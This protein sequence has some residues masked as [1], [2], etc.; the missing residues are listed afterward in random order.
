MVTKMIRHH[1]QD[2]REQD[3]SYHWDTVRLVLL[4][5]FAQ[6]GAGTFSNNQWIHMIHEGSS[7][8]IVEH[9]L[10][11]KKSLCSLR[12]I[13]GD[14][15]GIP[16]RPEMIGYNDWEEFTLRR[17]SS[18]DAQSIKGSGLIPGGKGNDSSRQAFFFTPLDE[19]GNNPDD[20][21][22][23]DDYTIPQK[24]HCKTCWEHNQDAFF[25]I[26]NIQSS[27]SRIAILA[28]EV[29]CDHHQ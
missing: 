14:S 27:R 7:R 21:T 24:V 9:C 11:N 16:I 20:E 3:G 1:D 25:V 15:G 5:A 19:F 8:K 12:A 6:K 4:K 22:L 17:R 10:D 26:K 13:Q 23:H 2:E 29:S 18:W 28:N